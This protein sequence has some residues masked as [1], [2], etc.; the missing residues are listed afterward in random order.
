MSPA[1][2]G[3]HGGAVGSIF[4][5]NWRP[6]T[7]WEV[8]PVA[9]PTPGAAVPVVPPLAVPVPVPVPDEEPAPLP[10]PVED[11]PPVAPVPLPAP[12]VPTPVPVPAVAVPSSLPGV[13][14][15]PSVPPSPAPPP[16]PSTR[17]VPPPP[18]ARRSV[19][20]GA[21][22]GTATMIASWS[23]AIAASGRY[24]FARLLPA[25][26]LL[27]LSDPRLPSRERAPSAPRSDAT[28]GRADQSRAG[29]RSVGGFVVV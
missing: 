3:T 14:S 17:A 20:P 7:Q 6:P 8:S 25:T 18:P 9:A 26:E 21:L 11:P 29:R 10:P 24:R 1:N 2:L 12:E 4:G 15:P 19:C 23:T 13:R 28:S 22:D 5:S 27:P 16:L